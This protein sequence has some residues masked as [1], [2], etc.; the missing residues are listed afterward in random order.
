MEQ[1]GLKIGQLVA[2][3]NRYA[4]KPLPQNILLGL[5]RWE[6]HG[7]EANIGSVLVLKVKS[8]IILD[9]LMASPVNKYI[10][11]RQNPT[12]AEITADSLPFIKAALIDMGVFAEI[13]PEV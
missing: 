11:S 8:E 6:K 13:K 7:Q 2:L 12:T 3:I 1:Q 10:L 4:R 9:Q 5:E